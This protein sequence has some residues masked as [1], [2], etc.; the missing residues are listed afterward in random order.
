MAGKVES[1]LPLVRLKHDKDFVWG[2][3][4]R[5]VFECIKDYLSKPPVLQTKN[6][7]NFQVIRGRTKGGSRIG[8]NPRG[9]R[10][11]VCHGI[12]KQEIIKRRN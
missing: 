7:Q 9:G 1:C 4:Q 8:A 10:R 11:R 5:E 12:R 6:W 2:A 3:A